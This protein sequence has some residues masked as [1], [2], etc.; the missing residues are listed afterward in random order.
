VETGVTAILLIGL[1]VLFALGVP[2]AFGLGLAT[3]FALLYGGSVPLIVVAQRVFTSLD[4][5]PIMAVLLFMLAGSIMDE[6]GMARRIINFASA[7]LGQFRASLA[8]IAVGATMLISGVSGSGTA[9]TAAVGSVM[10]PAMMKRGYEPRFVTAIQAAAGALGPI[11]PPSIIMVVLGSV[12]NTSIGQLFIG[13]IIPGIII[14]GFL[15]LV[16]YLHARRGGAAYEATERF[17]WGRVWTSFW[18]AIP[19]L[20]MAVLILGGILT[21]VFTAT[22]SAVMG[23]VYGFAVG[24]WVYRELRVN[25]IPRM[26]VEAACRSAIILIIIATA[27]LFGWLVANLQIP[28]VVARFLQDHSANWIVFMILVNALLLLLG[29]FMESIAV[30]IILMPIL[31]PVAQSFG[32]DLLH[33]GVVVSV[34]L[35]IGLVTPP[36]GAT[37]FVACS[38]AK[39]TIREVTPA[40]L[41]S[42]VVMIIVQAL[43]TF[44]PPL[45]TWLPRLFIP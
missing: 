18:Q 4:S 45:T 22:E 29:M 28:T 6:G 33:F 25:R 21:G 14:G 31:Y 11:I 37:L 35:A 40:L 19:G 17:S 1:P 15:M 2:I 10:I 12:T 44:I 27:G 7:L 20:G 16:C 24:L 34:N 23:V 3:T 8:M 43:I 13:G 42:I 30:I 36:Y 39:M 32:I 9:D 41:P 26:L 5:F 38:I